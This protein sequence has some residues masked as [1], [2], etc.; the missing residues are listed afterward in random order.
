MKRKRWH[1]LNLCLTSAVKTGDA[2]NVEFVLDRTIANV[3][4]SPASLRSVVSEL[5]QL[6]RTTAHVVE[7]YA[8]KVPAESKSAAIFVQLREREKEKQRREMN[9]EQ[10]AAARIDRRKRRQR[11][12]AQSDIPGL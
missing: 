2:A 4:L 9:P 5:L 6:G 10:K 12:V 11:V 8:T 1:L 7:R 3:A